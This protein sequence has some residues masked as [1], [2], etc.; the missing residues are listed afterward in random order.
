MSTGSAAFTTSHR[1]IVRVHDNTTVV[2]TLAEPAATSGL[3]VA[4]QVMIRIGNGTDRGTAGNEHHAGLTRRETKD[5]VVAFAGSE[6]CRCTGGAGHCGA[7]TGTELDVVNEGTYRNLGER[8]AVADLGSY[9]AARS[10]NL[11]NLD[12][13]RSDDV[14]LD[15]VLVLDESD[16]CAAVRIILDGLYRCGAFVLGT[17]EVDDAVHSLV[18]ATDVTHCHL[19]GVVAAASAL[20]GFE[21]S[22]VR[23]LGSD[24]SECADDLVPLTGSYRFEFSYCHNS[25]PP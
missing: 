10:D 3:S 16:A 7:L 9:A 18:T 14:F 11:T 13:V 17:E 5:C 8:E 2:R 24:L 21:K 12:A 19:A 25:Y 20:E 6:L 22:L 4:L 15:S 1:V 23:L